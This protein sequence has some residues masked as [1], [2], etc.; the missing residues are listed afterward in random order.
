MRRALAACMIGVLVAACSSAGTPTA[1]PGNSTAPATQAPTTTSSAAPEITPN[2]ETTA[3]P[4]ATPTATSAQPTESPN[5]S[6]WRERTDVA[7]GPSVREDHTWTVD[8]DGARAYLFG[9]RGADGASDELWSFDLATDTWNL[10]QPSGDRPAARFG[11]TGTWVPSVGLVIWSGQAGRRFFA[12][13]WAYDP[14]VNAWRELPALGDV[15]PARY[16]S[17]ASLGPE[18][19]LWISHGFT[20]DTGRFADTRAYDFATGEWTDMTPSGNVPVE[21]CLHDCFWS[22]GRLVLYAGQT[23]GVPALGDIWAYDPASEAWSRGPEAAA[24]PRQLYAL[25]TIADG[26][27]AWVFGGG[28]LEGDFLADT[29]RIASDTLAM[30]P[31]LMPLEPIPSARAGA[32]LI[33]DPG[34][35][36]RLLFGGRNDLGVLGDLWQLEDAVVLN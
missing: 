29:W 2:P 26:D 12:D 23:T 1:A 3:P 28:T 14:A 8:G 18:G 36:R 27:G 31:I 7:A 35:S 4:A 33:R 15:P 25:A 24:P 32:T 17:C 13:A 11:H 20:A 6:G 10:L 5:S 21:R 22:A 19:R 9:G 34:S 30:E 16:G